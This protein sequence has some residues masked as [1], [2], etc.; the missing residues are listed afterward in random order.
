MAKKK[1][2]PN[3]QPNEQVNEVV[4]FEPL[5]EKEVYQIILLSSSNLVKVDTEKKVSG[6]VANAL[7]KKG[8]AKLKNK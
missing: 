3:E 8:F 4:N 5:N 6:N 1:E 2:K 7:I